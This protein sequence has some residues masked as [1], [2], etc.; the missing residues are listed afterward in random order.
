M[1]S[2]EAINNI[3][4]CLPRSNASSLLDFHSP[5]MI[6]DHPVAAL[7]RVDPEKGLTAINRHYDLENRRLD[8]QLRVA[9]IGAKIA[10]FHDMTT[11]LNT[12]IV[13]HPECRNHRIEH[14]SGFLGFFRESISIKS[15]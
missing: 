7:S 1:N 12:Q 9:E 10:R 2:L 14:R 15:W 6:S 13:T 8:A 5:T 4:T 11:T 3:N